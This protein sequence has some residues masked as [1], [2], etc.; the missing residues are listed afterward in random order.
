[1]ARREID[2]HVLRSL[3]SK[4]YSTVTVTVPTQVCTR[5]ILTNVRTTTLPSQA[6]D[7]SIPPAELIADSAR[8]SSELHRAP[9]CSISTHYSGE[10]TEIASIPRP[11]KAPS[12]WI[13]ADRLTLL[14]S[15]SAEKEKKGMEKSVP[16]SPSQDTSVCGSENSR[17]HT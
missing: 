12:F 1:M 11:R 7:T 13:S 14:S 10:M 9:I 15:V 4:S 16:R 3:N 5:G 8:C 2:G 6:V 17:R